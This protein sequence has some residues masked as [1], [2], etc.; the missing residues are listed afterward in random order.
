VQHG[1][2]ADLSTEM[3]WIGGKVTHRIGGRAEQD[4][5]D[6]TLVLEGD[7]G[8]RHR[9]SEDHVEIGNRQ[10][11]GLARL[12][13]FGARQTLALRAMSVTTRV[14]SAAAEAAIVALLDMPAQSWGPAELDGGHDAPLDAT[15]VFAMCLSECFAMAAEYIRHLKRRTHRRGSA[16]WRHLEA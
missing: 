2:G 1:D 6:G 15:K 12:K 14:V 7:F 11:L 9:Q 10:Q 8:G 16:R 13:P 5:I 3:L 4:R